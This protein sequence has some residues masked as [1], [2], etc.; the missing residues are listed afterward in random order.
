M[1][2]N[3]IREILDKKG[4]TQEELALK[5]DMS[6]AHVNRIINGK[7]KPDK[8][9]ARIAEALDVPVHAL[10]D[11]NIQTTV[12]ALE[13]LKSLPNNVIKALGDKKK[14]DY[15]LLGL[16]LSDSTLSTEEIKLVVEEWERIER[17]LKHIKKCEKYA[18]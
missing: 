8:T 12:L 15:I 5:S 2:G 1:I 17:K 7:S 16:A 11:D 14:L 9:I 6:V 18:K 13:N 3:K 4:M 10:Y